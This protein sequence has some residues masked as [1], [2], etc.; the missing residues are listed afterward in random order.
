MLELEKIVLNLVE[1]SGTV[2]EDFR[3]FLT[4]MPDENFPTSILQNSV[5]LTVEPPKGM[6]ANIKRTYQGMINQNFLEDCSK[7]EIWR[8]LLFTLSYV[9]S[10]F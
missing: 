8:K 3:L 2:H 10:V 1:I 9:H 4:S 7:P 6:K 5:K